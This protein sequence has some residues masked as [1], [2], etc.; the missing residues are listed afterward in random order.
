MTKILCRDLPSKGSLGDN[1]LITEWNK[2]MKPLTQMV[3][4]DQVK[5]RQRKCR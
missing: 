5:Q 3:E 4:Q 2:K 1:D